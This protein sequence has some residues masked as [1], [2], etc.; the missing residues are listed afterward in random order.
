MTSRSGGGDI[1]R[2]CDYGD[3]CEPAACLVGYTREWRPMCA[4]HAARVMGWDYRLSTR[5]LQASEPG[6]SSGTG[7]RGR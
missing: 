6:T 4:R 1:E 2:R 7:G 3:C 5:V